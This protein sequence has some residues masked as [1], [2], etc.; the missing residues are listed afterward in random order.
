VLGGLFFSFSVGKTPKQSRD[1]SRKGDP[2]DGSILITVVGALALGLVMIL[3]TIVDA[4]R[5]MVRLKSYWVGQLGLFIYLGMIE[6][7]WK[8]AAIIFLIYWLL[9]LSG[10][11]SRDN[12]VMEDW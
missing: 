2:M 11:L 8:G 10:L 4:F 12:E 9:G 6:G 1:H 7:F 5:V 3:R